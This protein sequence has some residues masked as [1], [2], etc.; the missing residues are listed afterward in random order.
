M[1]GKRK[2]NYD[3]AAME[4]IDEL[5]RLLF[6]NDKCLITERT[7]YYDMVVYR[8]SSSEITPVVKRIYTAMSKSSI[9]NYSN[10]VKIGLELLIKKM[11][12]NAATNK[13]FKDFIPLI[14]KEDGSLLYY[15]H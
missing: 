14:V 11:T 4:D 10:T 3:K 8:I 6:G 13:P 1:F 2:C 5:N 7:N 12:I 15:T 9:S